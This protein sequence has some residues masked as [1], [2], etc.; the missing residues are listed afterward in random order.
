MGRTQSDKPRKMPSR[1]KHGVQSEEDR[2]KTRDENSS[3]RSA[4]L[5][6]RGNLLIHQG[7]H[8]PNLIQKMRQ[9]KDSD[10]QALTI[11]V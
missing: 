5:N 1:E 4:V 9:K 11:T 6:L 7:K 2:R 8:A 3:Y 10:A